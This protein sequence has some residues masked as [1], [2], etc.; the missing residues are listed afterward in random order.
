MKMRLKVLALWALHVTENSKFSAF[1]ITEN[2]KSRFHTG[3]HL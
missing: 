1:H 2:Q 3:P